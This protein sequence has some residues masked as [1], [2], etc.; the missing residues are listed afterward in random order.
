MN[1]HR[2]VSYSSQHTAQATPQHH[3]QSLNFQSSSAHQ[4]TQNQTAQQQTSAVAGLKH[5][6]QLQQLNAAQLSNVTFNREAQL[7]RSK[8]NSYKSF[9]TEDDL[10]FCPSNEIQSSP[11][12]SFASVLPNTYM[13]TGGGQRPI[14]R[15]NG[16]SILKSSSPFNT[17]IK[18]NV[19]QPNK[20]QQQQQQQQSATAVSGLHR[21][22]TPNS[23]MSPSQ[24][25][26]SLQSPQMQRFHHQEQTSSG[27][28]YASPQTQ[29]LLRKMDGSPIY[30]G[31]HQQQQQQQQRI[32]RNW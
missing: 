18:L 9:N 11:N 28:L 27:N 20:Q 8:L 31:G 17:P 12:S 13:A 2:T 24:H 5:R 15:F 23:Y 10:E 16:G 3:H 22:G 26:A 7:A 30:T 29:G 25:H 4:Q 21:I 6:Q 19:P 32:H 1:L 14:A